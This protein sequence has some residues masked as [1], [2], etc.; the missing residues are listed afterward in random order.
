MYLN[1]VIPGV[2]EPFERN[3]VARAVHE[4]AKFEAIRAQF[5]EVQACAGYWNMLLFS[6]WVRYELVLILLASL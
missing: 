4:K 3:N 6:L 2:S 1:L 5:A